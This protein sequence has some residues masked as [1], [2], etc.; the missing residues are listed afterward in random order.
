MLT[1]D[2]FCVLQRFSK[3]L[4]DFNMKLIRWRWSGIVSLRKWALHE[5]EKRCKE[6]DPW[7]RIQ[8]WEPEKDLPVKQEKNKKL[9]CH[10]SQTERETGGWRRSDLWQMNKH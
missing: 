2:Q 5:K 3:G 9:W 6:N 1:E 8:P 7:Y 4:R 10:E